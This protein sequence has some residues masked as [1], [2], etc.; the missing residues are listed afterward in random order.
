[1]QSLHKIYKNHQQNDYTENCPIPVN[2]NP[3]SKMEY[4][5]AG[6]AESLIRQSKHRAD[7]L[8]RLAELECKEIISRAM[9]EAAESVEEKKKSGYKAGFEAGAEDGY[10][11]GFGVGKQESLNKGREFVDKAKE[12]L[13]IAHME[14]RDYIEKTEKEIIDLSI[15]IAESVIQKEVEVDDSI[16]MRIAK[17]A[18]AEVRNRSQIVV[19]AGR[20]ESMMLQDRLLELQELCPNGVFTI[21]RDET[22]KDGG[23][24]IETEI[25]VIDATVDKQLENVKRALVEAGRKHGE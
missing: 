20:Q 15:K 6:Q 22:I 25:H 14:S 2:E 24:I 5:S 12:V 17:A 3:V 18:L 9:E 1:M 21:L 4:S 13:R 16:I 10:K 19:R 11:D 8:I 7:E 23:C